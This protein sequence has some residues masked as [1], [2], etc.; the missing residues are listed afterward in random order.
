MEGAFPVEDMSESVWAS[1]SSSP[2]TAGT[3][4]S[5]KLMSRSHSEWAFQMFLQEASA[6][7]PSP[8]SP[9][10]AQ[11]AHLKPSSASPVRPMNPA[12]DKDETQK[13]NLVSEVSCSDY[14]QNQ[15]NLACSAAASLSRASGTKIPASGTS[16]D[17]RS[18]VSDGPEIGNQ[19]PCKEPGSSIQSSNGGHYVSI[20]AFAA[21]NT[22]CTRP[23]TSGSSRE[24]SDDEELEGDTE[25][26]ENMIPG[27]VKRVRRMLSNRE[28]ARRSRRRKQEHLKE[29][30]TQVSQLR[31]ENSTLLKRLTDINQKFN[32]AAVNNR[33]LKADVET[34]RA[35]VKMAEDTVKR[36]TGLNPLYPNMGDLS[37]LIIPLIAENPTTAASES[38]IQSQNDPHPFEQVPLKG[39]PEPGLN[40][41]S[42][43]INHL[44]E[45]S[46]LIHLQ[47]SIQGAASRPP[48]SVQWDGSN[49]DPKIHRS[50]SK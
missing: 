14:L 21:M 30:E 1:S 49:W 36:V 40:P 2:P 45:H 39:L 8:I 37:S 19:A 9:S 10:H 47:T 23:T 42:S 28:S 17:Q 26:T 15:L 12:K 31:V 24:Q 41:H 20:S 6:E 35:K 11:I 29:L 44:T 7:D 25:I 5:K 48:G 22:N 3:S 43:H 33:I 27:D 13:R 38:S 16:S 32:E 18:V 46:D 4:S 50:S 34:W